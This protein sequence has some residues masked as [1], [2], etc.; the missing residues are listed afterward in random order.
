MHALLNGGVPYVDI[1]ASEEE[2]RRAAIVSELH[3]RLGTV[4]M[5]HHRFLGG[6]DRQETEYADGTCVQVDFTTNEY[7]IYS[8]AEGLNCET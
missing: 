5:T 3:K 6:P 7:K 1:D 2:I 8:K 4:E